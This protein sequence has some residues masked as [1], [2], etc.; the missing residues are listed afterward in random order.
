MPT[1]GEIVLPETKPE[2]EWIL[3]RAVQKSMPST[4]HSI[5]QGAFLRAL[6]AWGAD[7][8]IVGPEWRF[9]AEPVG[10]V[11]RPIM[12]DV[13][14]FRRYDARVAEDAGIGVAEFPDLVL[15]L[16]AMFAELDIFAD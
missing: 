6:Y 14:F 7:L 8:G 15:P 16:R 5:L 9:R 11:R 12:P 1:V 2:T 10:E 3:D 13:A 4:D